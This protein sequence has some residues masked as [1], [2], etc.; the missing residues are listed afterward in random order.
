VLDLDT[1]TF[2][3]FAEDEA[4]ELYLAGGFRLLRIIA[5]EVFGDGFES[6][7]TSAW[8]TAVGVE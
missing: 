7:N 2:T 4:G 1:F 6:G 3:G 8:S 5:D